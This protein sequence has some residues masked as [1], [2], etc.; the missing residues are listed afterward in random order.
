MTPRI[1]VVGGGSTHWTPRLLVDFAN[2]PS[3]HNADVTLVDLDPDS[4]PP[5]LDVA[6]DVVRPIMDRPQVVDRASLLA[7]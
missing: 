4:L 6:E 1:T 5:M 7:I 3:L 2:T